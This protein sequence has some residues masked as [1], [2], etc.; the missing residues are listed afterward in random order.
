M[1]F[2]E[3]GATIFGLLQG[4]LVMLNKRCNWIAYIT[5]MILMVVFSL[6]VNLY[7][8]WKE[9]VRIFKKSLIE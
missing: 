8:G 9:I 3:I 5:Q 2:F 7:G 1:E 4:L 6:S